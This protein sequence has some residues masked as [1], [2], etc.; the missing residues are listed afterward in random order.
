MKRL[1]SIVLV[2]I[3]TFSMPVIISASDSTGSIIDIGSIT[4]EF[5][6]DSMFTLDEQHIIAQ[7]I[8]CNNANA[9]QETTY[10]ILCTLFGHKTS[11][12]TISVIEHCVSNTQP[13]C[14]QSYQD[15]T[16]CSRCDYV[17]IQ[18]LSSMYI[19]CCE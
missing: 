17:Y 13:R 18:E 5:N 1:L 16:A 9:D 12:E 7:Q 19:F 3:I 6:A 8:A 10:N 14:I 15:V 4:V 2:I 11:T